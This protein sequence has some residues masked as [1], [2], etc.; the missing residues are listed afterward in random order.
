MG[1]VI[2]QV[3]P[4]LLFCYGLS[5]TLIAIKQPEILLYPKLQA[6]L[7]DVFIESALGGQKILLYWKLITNIY[8][9]QL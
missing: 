6:E 3:V 5:D 1:I 9:Y 2:S 8:F 4:I 7:G